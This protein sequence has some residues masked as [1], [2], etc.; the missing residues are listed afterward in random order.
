MKNIESKGIGVK[1]AA[2][3][4][5]V[6]L[7][8]GG[9]AGAH[10]FPRVEVTTKVVPDAN[11][12]SELAVA[13]AQLASAQSAGADLQAQLKASEDEVAALKAN[14]V[15]KEVVTNN[16]DYDK[17]I[18]VITDT[19]GQ[20]EPVLDG[21][22]DL[23]VAEVSARYVMAADFLSIAE[24][25]V[26]KSGLDELDKEVVTLANGSTLT[27]NSEDAGR[28]R[29]ED[30]PGFVQFSSFDFDEKDAK[31]LVEGNFRQDG[32]TFDAQFEVT[33]RDGK[34]RRIQVVSVT[35]RK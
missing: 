27:I 8:L 22:S 14:P 12:V 30:S 11:V 3:G 5:V 26:K 24:Q 20:T 23:E 13:K 18:R 33:I 10:L 6:L 16:D 29:L 15:I 32:H 19:D 21:L 7:G 25:E 34:Y 17:V 9:F 31:V 2:I 4:G 35:E 28:F 1:A